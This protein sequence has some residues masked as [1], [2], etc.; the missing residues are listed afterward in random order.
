[1][2]LSIRPATEADIAA[3]E[4]CL[5]DGKAA[6]ASLGIPQWQGEYPNRIDIAEDIAHGAAYVAETD[7]G[8]LVGT[9]ALSFDGDE[10]Y[11]VI[12]G[13]WLTTSSAAAPTYA[14]IHR[15]AVSAAAA[16]RGVMSFM[17][18]ACERI[19]RERGAA[20]IRIDT[21]ERNTPLQGLAAKRGYT[22]C[23]TITLPYEGETDPLRIAFEK[24]LV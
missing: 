7:D 9:L 1:M 4:Q 2:H 14:V 16:H 19:A 3:A 8:A 13:A 10:T 11:D 15:C 6:L 5:T 17:F 18:E 12:D 22:R 24:V 23:G 21:H 20:S